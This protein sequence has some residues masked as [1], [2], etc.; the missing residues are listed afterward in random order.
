MPIKI[1]LFKN[2][3]KENENQPDYT[4]YNNQTGD[5]A[6]GWIKTANNGSEYISIKFETKEEK[7]GRMRGLKQE[8]ESPSTQNPDDDFPF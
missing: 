4:G 2:D 8:V 1:A 5:S 3:K 6:A 7:E